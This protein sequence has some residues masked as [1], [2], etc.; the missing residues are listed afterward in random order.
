MFFSKQLQITQ[1]LYQA[2][3]T[4]AALKALPTETHKQ[5]VACFGAGSHQYTAQRTSTKVSFTVLLYLSKP[6]FPA[7]WS[8]RP[9]SQQTKNNQEESCIPIIFNFREALGSATLLCST[10]AT[11]GM[12][13]SQAP[14]RAAQRSPD[15]PRQ[16]GEVGVRQREQSRCGWDKPAGAGSS[17]ERQSRLLLCLRP[18]S[19]SVPL[20]I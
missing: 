7:F 18:T 15:S 2:L 5:N 20:A 16:P 6:G 12:P 8:L 3:F 19:G 13:L 4:L 9:G 11:L 17:W 14:C 10:Q 1:Y